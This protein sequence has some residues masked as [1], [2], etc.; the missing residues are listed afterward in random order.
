MRL[1]P[2]LVTAALS[3]ATAATAALDRPP[4]PPRAQ[5][6]SAAAPRQQDPSKQATWPK[7]EKRDLDRARAAAKQFRKK[8]T[9]LHEAAADQLKRMGAGVAP[10]LIRL[11][12]DK[13]QNVNE[14]L[15]SVLDA[16]V[17]SSHAALMARE[18]RRKSVA[19]RRY[20]VRR[21]A[22]MRDRDML[23]VLRKL[24]DDKDADIA[25]FAALGAL[26]LGDGAGVDKVLEAA[27]QRWTEQRALIAATLAPA[28]SAEVSRL[29]W[30]RIGQA[31]P[32]DQMAGLRVL[33]HLATKEQRVL[34]GEAPLEKLSSFQAIN[35]AKKWLEK[36]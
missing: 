8:Q 7:L 1:L 9:E 5:A 10:V 12:S 3:L 27:R 4:T 32:T 30:E 14:H 22:G 31:R 13:A 29:I 36:L 2:N 16:V 18:V 19:C 21:L 35:L 15:F 20:V 26:A 33:R 23:P 11:I 6:S 17:D 25:F 24:V 28:R 34:H